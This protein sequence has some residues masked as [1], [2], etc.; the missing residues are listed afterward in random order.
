VKQCVR[1][2]LQTDCTW[3][4]AYWL[5]SCYEYKSHQEE[6]RDYR[7]LSLDVESVWHCYRPPGHQQNHEYW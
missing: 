5:T 2:W 1:I 3:C 4:C 6:E 7:W